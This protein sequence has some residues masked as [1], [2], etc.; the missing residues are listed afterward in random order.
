MDG[1]SQPCH[2]AHAHVARRARAQKLG[3]AMGHA[4][5]IG[6]LTRPAQQHG[7]ACHERLAVIVC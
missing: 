7:R 1:V 6:L 4:S 3:T 2:I 5:P